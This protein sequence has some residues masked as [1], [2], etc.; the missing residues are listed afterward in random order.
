MPNTYSVK[1]R[2]ELGNERQEK[3]TNRKNPNEFL[4]VDLQSFDL[5]LT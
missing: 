5:P 1:M 4:S 3:D 2:H